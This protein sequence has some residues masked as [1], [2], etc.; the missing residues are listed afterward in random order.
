M[1]GPNL[2]SRAHRASPGS[3]TLHPDQEVAL[4]SSG[5]D[6]GASDG[7]AGIGSA[8]GSVGERGAHATVTA[9][10]NEQA[11]MSASSKRCVARR[12][13]LAASRNPY[14]DAIALPA[15]GHTCACTRR[16]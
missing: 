14:R 15:P 3:S 5:H 12:R 4:L 8:A 16:C 13:L 7:S 1:Q 11:L 10:A 2:R 9:A 6:P